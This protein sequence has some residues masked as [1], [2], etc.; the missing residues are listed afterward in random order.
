MNKKFGKAMNYYEKGKINKALEICEDILLEGL[1]NPS[2]LNFKGL[3]LYQKGNLNEAIIA[4]KINKDLNNDDIAKNYIKDTIADER[5]IDLYKQGEQALKQFKIDKALELFKI[6]SESDF[7]S[8]KVN[9]GIAICYQ[10][11]GDLYKAKEYIDKALRIDNNAITAKIIEKELKEDGVYLEYQNSSK[12]FLMGITS[13]FMILAIVAGAYLIMLKVKDKKL[14][15]NI[16]DTK[17]NQVIDEKG[18]IKGDIKKTEVV[19]DESKEYEVKD[20]LEAKVETTSGEVIRESPKS[21]SFD[22]EKLEILMESND[23]DGVY[24]QLKNVKAELISSEDTE[25][26]NHAIR[27]MENE[28]VSK[29][30]EY[31]LWYLNKGNYVDAGI[32][33]DKAYAYCGGNYLKEHVLFYRAS[34]SLK[35]WDNKTALLQYE[36]YYNKYPKGVYVEEVLYD[37]ALISNSVD[38]EKSKNYA[39]TLINEFPTSIYINDNIIRITTS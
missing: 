36:E 32:S 6:C 13:L 37:L 30:Y 5:R 20:T 1:N 26:Y 7:N 8:I 24:E 23:L 22:K 11:N 25:V 4:W 27:L 16:Q 31:G 18:S 17:I 29:F 35:K 14:A 3:L 2:V 9:T 38:K 33:L 21:T 34:N 10:K 12:G 28:G 19:E 39:N 15:D